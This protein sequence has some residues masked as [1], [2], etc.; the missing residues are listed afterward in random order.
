MLES[1]QAHIGTINDMNHQ[2]ATAAEEQSSVASE[3]N[4]FI[5]SVFTLS[6]KVSDNARSMRASSDELLQENNELQRRMHNFKV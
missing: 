2:V 4:R 6:G 3:V 1:V 5:E